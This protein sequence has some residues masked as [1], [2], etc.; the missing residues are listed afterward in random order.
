VWSNEKRAETH[1]HHRRDLLPSS[2]IIDIITTLINDWSS[3]PIT[4]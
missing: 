1:S 2:S 3:H 4:P